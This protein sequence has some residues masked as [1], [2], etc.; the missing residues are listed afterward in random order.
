MAGDSSDAADAECRMADEMKGV[1]GQVGHWGNTRDGAAQTG[2]RGSGGA[3]QS[4][5]VLQ[6]RR[7]CHSP[8]LRL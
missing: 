8:K 4:R 6:V 7:D 2:R 3:G 1:T 5:E